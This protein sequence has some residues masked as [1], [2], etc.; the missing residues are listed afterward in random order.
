MQYTVRAFASEGDQSQ[1]INLVRARPTVRITDFPSLIDL[2]EMFGLETIRANTGLWFD[3]HDQLVG[4]AILDET[5]LIAET[6]PGVVETLFPCIIAWAD[7]RN[8]GNELEMMC[9]DSDTHQMVLLEQH[10]FVRQ[11]GGAIHMQRSLLTPIPDPMLPPGFVIRPITGEMEVAAHVTLHRAAW[12]TDYMTVEYRLS[13]MRTPSY[14]QALDLLAVAPDGRLAAYCMCYISPEENALSGSLD[15]HTDP[16]ATHPDFQCRGLAG[17]LLL[18]GMKLL[19]ARGMETAKLGTSL[20]NI[21]MQRAA[22]R[23]G[24][25]ATYRTVSYAR[26]RQ[27]GR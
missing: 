5:N 1:I 23:V 6:L 8:Q 24:F 4:Y 18:A 2:R 21:A 16:I 20:D 7:V 17:A 9:R 12:H 26:P 10:G 25:E 11:L 14:D 27:T 3:E 19:R 13:M 22:V 15:G